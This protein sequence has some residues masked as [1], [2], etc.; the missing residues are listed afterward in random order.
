MRNL[1][2]FPLFILVMLT[3]LSPLAPALAQGGPGGPGGWGPGMM[4]W[5]GMMRGPGMWG[6]RGAGHFCNPGMAGFA[7]WRIDQIERVV[8]PN[9]AQRKA[10]QE[11]RAASAKAAELIAGACPQQ[12]PA[13]TSERLALMEKRMESMLQAIKTTRPAFEAFY[14]TLSDEQK[15]RLDASGPR[16]WGWNRWGRSAR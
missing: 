5:P 8:K 16:H 10:L 15:Q 3:L 1:R 4:M 6:P 14:G 2:T 9:E 13:T 12:I 7:E 11:L